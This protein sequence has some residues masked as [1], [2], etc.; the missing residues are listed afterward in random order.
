MKIQYRPA[1]IADLAA[2]SEYIQTRLHNPS[3]AA[4]LRADVLHG[5]SRLAD[6]PEMGT[7]LRS[8]YEEI[9][10]DVRFL[11]IRKQMI[12]YE[13]HGQSIEIIRILDGSTDYLAQLFG[14]ID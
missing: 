12:F 13:V 5:I 11:V 8:K 4:K 1:A 9:E 2:T 7:L 6:T 3:A 14:C 10:S